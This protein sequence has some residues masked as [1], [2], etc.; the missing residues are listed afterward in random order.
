[1]RA[2]RTQDE[3]HASAGRDNQRSYAKIRPGQRRLDDTTAETSALRQALSDQLAGATE[4]PFGCGKD[5]D[6]GWSRLAPERRI[7]RGTASKAEHRA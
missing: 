7:Y 5:G 2:N 3:A 6:S 4:W 1:V